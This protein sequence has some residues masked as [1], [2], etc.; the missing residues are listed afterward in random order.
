GVQAS[1]YHDRRRSAMPRLRPLALIL[2]LLVALVALPAQG[3]STQPAT[4]PATQPAT[5]PAG[6]PEQVTTLLSN[7][8][9]AY[10][11]LKGLR[12]E[13]TVTAEYD[14]AGRAER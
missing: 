6:E 14:V 4:R 3:R 8:A 1:R 12:L 9:E 11:Q 5:I 7:V 2:P 13:A 10:A